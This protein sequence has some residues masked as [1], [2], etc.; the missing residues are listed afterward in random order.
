MSP[1]TR[2]ALCLLLLG[3][4]LALTATSWGVATASFHQ[5]SR[6]ATPH[7][8]ESASHA[9]WRAAV[10]QPRAVAR[11]QA[12][13]LNRWLF[14]ATGRARL[15]LGGLLVAL[16]AWPRPLRRPAVVAT[17][18]AAL[19]AAAQC[20]LLLPWADEAG[21]ALAMAPDPRPAALQAAARAMGPIH[22]LQAA[23]DL[24]TVGLLL[25]AAWALTRDRT[26]SGDGLDGG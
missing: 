26:S 24:A 3:A 17:S 13:E 20:L 15:V 21:R 14:R 10:A 1:P 22:A 8:A 18:L 9:A 12:A 23:A 19:V 25:A 2:T 7:P 5:A 16:L 11:Y 6:L 4:W